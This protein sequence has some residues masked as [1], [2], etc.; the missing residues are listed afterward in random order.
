[1]KFT[2]FLTCTPPPPRVPFQTLEPQQHK[3]DKQH[4]MQTFLWLASDL[5]YLL[6][7]QHGERNRNSTTIKDPAT[8]K[9]VWFPKE[10][11]AKI[12]DRECEYV[13]ALFKADGIHRRRKRTRVISVSHTGGQLGSWAVSLRTEYATPESK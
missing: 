8:L 6:G 12:I 3:Q 9:F 2:L 7:Y 13:E 1:M 11:N 5:S 4:K 10:V